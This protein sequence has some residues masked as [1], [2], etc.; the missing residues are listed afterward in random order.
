MDSHAAVLALGAV[1]QFQRDAFGIT[2]KVE[3]GVGRIFVLADGLVR[4]RF[5]RNGQAEADFSYAVVKADWPPAGFEFCDSDSVLR[6][7]SP[8]LSVSIRK[9]DGAITVRSASGMALLEEVHVS[10]NGDVVRLAW[11]TPGDREVFGCGEK[12][13]PL[14][15]RGAP[16]RM[17]NADRY[18]FSTGTDPL[19]HCIPFCLALDGGEAHGLFVDNTFEQ[20]W[21]LGCPGETE[22]SVE[23][24]GGAADFYVFAGPTPAEVLSRYTEL[25]GRVPLPPLWVVGYQQSRYAYY[26][27][28]QLLGVA[29]EFRRRNI[30]CDVLYLDVLYMDRYKNFTWDATRFPDPRRM[31]SDLKADGF[32]TVVILDPGVKVEEGYEPFE[33]LRAAGFYARN[34]DGSPF[35]GKEWP[36]ECIFPDFTDAQCRAWWGT[37][38]KG[39]TDD[40]VAGL[41]N[42]MNEPEVMDTDSHTMPLDVRQAGDGIVPGEHKRHHNVY[43][44]Q[45]G[46]ATYD[47]LRTLR[48]E[49][50][51]FVLARAGFAGGQ[52]YAA[53]WTGD[54]VSSWEHLR[55]GIPMTLNLGLSGQAIS[56]PDVGGFSSE[57]SA[58]MFG[59]WLQANIL[60][61]FC[62]VH[63]AKADSDT[64]MAEGKNPQE[65]WT[66][67]GDWEA[68][69]RR[70][71][72]LRY[73]LLPYLYTVFEEMTRTGAPIVRPLFFE[74]PDDPQCR[75]RDYQYLVGRDIMCAP[76]VEDGARTKTLYLPEGDWYDFRTNERLKGGRE[77]TVE[78][79]VEHL[80]MYIRAGAALPMQAIVQHT[81][82][83][84]S[85]PIEWV[86]WPDA[87]GCADGVVY[88]DDG[89]SME[90]A[91]GAFRRTSV[92]IRQGED[93]EVIEAH[94]IGDYVSPRPSFVVRTVQ[95]GLNG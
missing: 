75:N 36:G 16:M 7:S 38:C 81:G 25:T 84:D 11:G 10:W 2:L 53:T 39:L 33:Q 17:W 73:R 63:S 69:N 34:P 88:E 58:E 37:M 27:E 86:A 77:I 19:Y 31:I 55:L 74:Y 67:G 9:S 30:P 52:R 65:P 71:I 48:P 23:C 20:R 47:G 24:D 21:D 18:A 56:G 26:P 60:F 62:R 12:A 80:P 42:D 61:P 85:V 57:A 14:D 51:A 29:A 78:A 70:Y 87:D 83:C 41:W 46:R 13:G 50:R 28:S 94:S 54:N 79:P 64:P 40:G 45:M 93:G 49:E 95:P 5:V 4:V 59:R 43:G 89:R 22:A 92:K 1:E 68:T 3:N 32:Q 35:V 8:A 90:Y 82:Q 44:M 72:E 66:F 6:I 91:H 15:R 76:V